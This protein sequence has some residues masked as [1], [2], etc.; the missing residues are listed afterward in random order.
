[1]PTSPPPAPWRSLVDAVVWFHRAMPQAR[2]TL[3]PELAGR[4]TLPVT[5]ASLVAYH[6]GPVGPYGELL[7]S[8]VLLRGGLGSGHV[9]FIA[10]DSPASVAGGRRNWA[11]PKQLATFDGAPG[12]PGRV[13][14]EGDGWALE[15]TTRARSRRLPLLGTGR[16]TQVWPDGIARTFGVT[17]RGRL[18]AG[19]VEVDHRPGSPL[20][21]LLRP[22]RHPALLVSG[23]QLVEPPSP[24]QA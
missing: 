12:R 6:R 20:T 7:A 16:C 2:A 9:P 13:L 10:V 19:W 18:Q 5:T 21:A 22:G 8:P 14:V 1:M 15:V 11:L 17:M 4:G 23:V 24:P 3:P